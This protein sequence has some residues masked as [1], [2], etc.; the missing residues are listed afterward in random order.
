MDA[1]H[2]VKSVVG[3]AL[4]HFHAGSE[5]LVS[6]DAELTAPATISV[7][8]PAFEANGAIPRKYSAE[9]EN[10]S[11]PLSWSGLPSQ[12]REL[13]L[14]CEDPD[15]P[16]TKPFIHWLLYGLSP[17][18][19]E[20]PEGIPTMDP[21]ASM[22]DARQGQ[23]STGQVGYSG[24]MPPVGH[25]LHHYHFQLFALDEPVRFNYS[26]KREDVIAAMAGHVLATGDLVGTYEIK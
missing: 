10:V 20:L 19:T 15:A 22:P 17:E 13:L 23:N 3:H 24:P 4:R 26:P 21:L 6:Y 1:V 9:G 16:K 11:P 8:S 14:I 2:G 7:E 5:K 18:R 12:T 25:G